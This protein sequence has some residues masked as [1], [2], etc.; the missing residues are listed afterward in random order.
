MIRTEY[1]RIAP[2]LDIL[3]TWSS[4]MSEALRRRYHR[5]M[6]RELD[7]SEFLRQ[8]Y[9]RWCRAHDAAFDQIHRFY[10]LTN[11]LPVAGDRLSLAYSDGGEELCIEQRQ[12]FTTLNPSPMLLV[13][14]VCAD[15]IEDLEEY[16][17][18]DYVDEDDE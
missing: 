12:L 10:K 1:L 16:Q 15:E 9:A 17:E 3:V 14:Y 4:R 13:Y 7:A 18:G 5:V 6:H 8:G 2:D 11:S